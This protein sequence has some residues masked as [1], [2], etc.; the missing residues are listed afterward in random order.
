M[1]LLTAGGWLT[2][3]EL[4]EAPHAVPILLCALALGAAALV[5]GCLLAAYTGTLVSVAALAY[6]H[7]G[8]APAAFTISYARTSPNVR[9]ARPEFALFSRPPPALS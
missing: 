4:I 1:L 6:E 9:R 2:A 7:S 3:F 8:V 5:F